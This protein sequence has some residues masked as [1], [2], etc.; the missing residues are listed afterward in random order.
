[1][2]RFIQTIHHMTVISSLPVNE[3]PPALQ[4]KKA[5]MDRFWKPSSSNVKIQDRFR[6]L[7]QT[8]MVDSLDSM[9][10]HYEETTVDLAGK[11][12]LHSLSLD[13][14]E[15]ARNIACGWAKKNYRRKLSNETLVK[16][17][18]L[19]EEIANKMTESSGSQK[20]SSQSKNLAPSKRSREVTPPSS[21][22]NPLPPPLV[23]EKR[24]RLETPS[25]NH[26]DPPKSPGPQS[27]DQTKSGAQPNE[28]HPAVNKIQ[29]EEKQT[30]AAKPNQTLDKVSI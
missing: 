9:K 10:N 8:Y 1:M 30:L 25:E 4:R 2:Y 3:L 24:Q 7:S 22:S 23:N 5:E 13:D 21:P 18:T 14:F 17:N 16:L 15:K 12:K 19:C 29:S 28:T 6:A 11:L 27:E 26:P 20:S